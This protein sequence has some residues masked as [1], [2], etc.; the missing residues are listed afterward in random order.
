MKEIKITRPFEPAEPVSVLKS[1]EFKIGGF[2]CFGQTP[3]S[4]K[5]EFNKSQYFPGDEVQIRVHCDNSQ[6]KKDVDSFKIKLLVYVQGHANADHP[7]VS[8]AYALQTK[9]KSTCKKHEKFDGILQTRLPVNG[10]YGD[11]LPSS[12]QGK[13]IT[14]S[15]SLMFVVKHDAW[16]EYGIGNEIVHPITIVHDTR[17]LMAANGIAKADLPQ[18]MN[19]VPFQMPMENVLH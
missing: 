6:C 13:L 17:E 8:S 4:I 1:L 10:Y 9:F 14:V 3:C 18:V 2:C 12:V 7:T 16:N 5:A 19:P 11:I 15:Y